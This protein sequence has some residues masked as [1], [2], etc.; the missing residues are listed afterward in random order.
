MTDSDRNTSPRVARKERRVSR[1]NSV[2]GASLLHVDVGGRDFL[3][4]IAYDHRPEQVVSLVPLL[5]PHPDEVAGH[6]AAAYLALVHPSHALVHQFVVEL[7]EL[8]MLDDGQHV[9]VR[10]RRLAAHQHAAAV[11]LL[12]LPVFRLAPHQAQAAPHRLLQ[13]DGGFGRAQRHNDADVVH[14]KAPRA[15]SARTR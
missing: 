1:G 14:V 3:L 2:K 7:H 6:V 12:L 5:Q 10:M 15:A 11:L 9:E 4:R 8:G 13:Q